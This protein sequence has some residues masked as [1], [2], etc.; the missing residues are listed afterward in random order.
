MTKSLYSQRQRALAAAIADQ[1]KAK[2]MTQAQVARAMGNTRH[3]PF[4][5][6]I[7]AGERRIDVV[8]LLR[9]ADVIGLDVHSLIDSL[10]SIPDE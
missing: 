2:G 1:R 10:T 5:A 4:I 9:L 3:Q 7:E 8:E 6:N